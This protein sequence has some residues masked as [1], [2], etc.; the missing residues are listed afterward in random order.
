MTMVSTTTDSRFLLCVNNADYPA[1]LE[2]RKVYASL[3]DPVA[4]ST[5]FV[6]VVN[7]SGEDYLY[8]QTLFIAVELPQAAE[9]MFTAAGGGTA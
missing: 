2:V 4:E 5:G 1:S 7:E 8:P 3:P 9:A 6:R